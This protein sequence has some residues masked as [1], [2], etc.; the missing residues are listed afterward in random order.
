VWQVGVHGLRGVFRG[1]ERMEGVED[2]L[3]MRMEILSGMREL[4]SL[5]IV[6]MLALIVRMFVC[7]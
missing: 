2:L 5:E 4:E 1:I 3:G 7:A 6:F